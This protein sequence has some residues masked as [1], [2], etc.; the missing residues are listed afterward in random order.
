MGN[1]SKLHRG[2]RVEESQQSAVDKRFLDKLE[3]GSV[4]NIRCGGESA[5]DSSSGDA[6][7]GEFA[8]RKEG[9]MSVAQ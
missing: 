3:A 1:N 7:G 2:Q 4:S 9:E 6:S 8:T 5:N